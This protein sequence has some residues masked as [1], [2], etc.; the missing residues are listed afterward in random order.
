[1][2]LEAIL[3][4]SPGSYFLV[5]QIQL[6]PKKGK[7]VYQDSICLFFSLNQAGKAVFFRLLKQMHMHVL[8]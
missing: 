3:A 2:H 8:E 5:M 1:M 6:L 7:M 4:M